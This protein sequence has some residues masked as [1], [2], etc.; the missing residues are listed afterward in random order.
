MIFVVLFAR[1]SLYNLLIHLVRV[2]ISEH[3]HEIIGC[4]KQDW[5]NYLEI[6]VIFG[7]LF[8]N[9]LTSFYQRPRFP[10]YQDP[11]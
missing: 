5:E 3:I 1:L 4:L 2:H 7:E 11:V 6:N 10:R 8:A 9:W